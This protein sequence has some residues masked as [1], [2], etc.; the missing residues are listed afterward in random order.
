MNNMVLV[1]YRDAG[2][3]TCTWFYIDNKQRCVSPYF[4]TEEEA[5]DWF[6]KIFDRDEE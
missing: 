4:D 2:M 5:K 6:Q 1:K 3:I